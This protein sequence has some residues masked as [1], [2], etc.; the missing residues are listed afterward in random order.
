[1]VHTMVTLHWSEIVDLL[2]LSLFTGMSLD[3]NHSVKVLET[4]QEY[5]NLDMEIMHY[6]KYWMWESKSLKDGW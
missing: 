1:M 4:S 3:A 6:D 2:W 5:G